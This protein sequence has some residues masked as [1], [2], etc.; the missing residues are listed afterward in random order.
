MT[1]YNLYIAI[2]YVTNS[3][4]KSSWF[5]FIIIQISITLIAVKSLAY[6]IIYLYMACDN[7]FYRL[8]SNSNSNITSKTMLQFPTVYSRFTFLFR[9]LCHPAQQ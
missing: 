6:L 8:H 1:R 9:M 4:S 7:C 5:K 3:S 2:T